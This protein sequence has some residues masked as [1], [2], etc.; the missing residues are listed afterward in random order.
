MPF[1]R[2]FP[3]QR[4]FEMK[5]HFDRLYDDFMHGRET[6]E[7]AGDFYPP[8]NLENTDE[9]YIATIE[10]AGINKKDVQ[11]SFHDGKLIV[12][13]EKK[14]QPDAHKRDFIY[15]EREYGKFFRK[16][17]IEGRINEAKIAAEFQDGVLEV[18]LPK[19]HKENSKRIHINIK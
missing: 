7:A 12:Q 2:N 6:E 9:E 10:L 15:Y 16:I 14:E 5:K 18:R 3:G 11:I 13:G 1:Y 8:V 4:I 17:P 19:E